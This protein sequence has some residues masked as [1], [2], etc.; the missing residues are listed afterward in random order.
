MAQITGQSIAFEPRIA[1]FEGNHPSRLE[2]Y[3]KA[4]SGNKTTKL[5]DIEKTG[6][7]HEAIATAET[8]M[9]T[10]G[11][12]P[13]EKIYSAGLTT[14]PL[15]SGLASD[16]S[17]GKKRSAEITQYAQ[18]LAMNTEMNDRIPQI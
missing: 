15:I 16:T 6:R 7:G 11:Q 2:L 3:Q 18:I 9:R 17:G 4:K 12:N 13:R 8:V 1:G 14:A 5:Q 10:L